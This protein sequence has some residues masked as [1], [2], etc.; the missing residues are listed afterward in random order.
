[1]SG[2]ARHVATARPA[3]V[4]VHDYGDVFWEPLRI[5]LLIK[6][7]FFSIQAGRNCCLQRYPL[8]IQ[9]ANIEIS[10]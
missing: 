7:C 10:I 5:Q 6:V 8:L 3:S 2:D 9:D 1:M 4:A